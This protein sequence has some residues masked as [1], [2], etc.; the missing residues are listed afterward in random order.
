M[1]IWRA[2]G[3]KG[4]KF[5]PAWCIGWFFMPVWCLW[6]PYQALREIWNASYDSKHWTNAH[7]FA[8]MKFWWICYLMS[9]VFHVLLHLQLFAPAESYPL[10]VNMSQIAI[11]RDLLTYPLCISAIMMINDIYGRQMLNVE[12]RSIYSSSKS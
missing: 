11:M 3:A 4:M 12:L 7:S 10:L 6:K 8:V 1:E 2:L 9:G 5:T